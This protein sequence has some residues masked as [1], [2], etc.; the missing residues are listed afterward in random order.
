MTLDGEY[1]KLQDM[2]T[3]MYELMHGNEEVNNGV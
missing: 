1:K 2:Q 3:E